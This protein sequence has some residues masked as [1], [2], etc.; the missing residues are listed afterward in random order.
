M[1]CSRM[2][3]QMIAD[4]LGVG[5]GTICRYLKALNKEWRT[6]MMD[7]IDKMMQRDLSALDAHERSANLEFQ[8]TRSPKWMGLI[9]KIMERR[10]KMLG[11]D[12][13]RVNE[14]AKQPIALQWATPT[15]M[16]QV[17]NENA[18]GP[19]GAVRHHQRN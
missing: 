17:R 4:A 16:E 14:D 13:T 9:L 3:Q 10:A 15:Q 7:T 5:V 19:N 18:G 2:T 1:Y 8:R 6:E 11:F 12:T